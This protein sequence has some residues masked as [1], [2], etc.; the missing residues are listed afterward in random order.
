SFLGVVDDAERDRWL[1]R[2]H[3]LTMPSRLPGA[4]FAGEGFGLV[5]IE[6]GAYGK[7]VVACN[8]GGA[9]DPVAD[10]ASGLLVEPNE[11]LA[12]A[13]AIAR[14]LL[15]DELAR[16]LGAAGRARAE[17]LAWPLVV[18]R[19]REVLLETIE[20]ARET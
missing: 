10:G 5:Y 7:P 12:L 9:L 14:L 11:P 2:A 8:V 15:D 19:M 4:G 20:N 16:R 1:R 13:E 17:S 3:V 18:S 6:A